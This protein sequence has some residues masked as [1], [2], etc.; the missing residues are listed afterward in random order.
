MARTGKQHASSKMVKMP[1][2][3]G[4]QGSKNGIAEWVVSHL[5][6]A[7]YFVDLFAGGCAVTHCALLSG[8]YKHVIANDINKVP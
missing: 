6:A 8:K 5:P 4:Y 1:Y 3:I 2:G 7:D